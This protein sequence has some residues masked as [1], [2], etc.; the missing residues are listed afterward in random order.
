[1]ITRTTGKIEVRT[2][3][4]SWKLSIYAFIALVSG[5]IALAFTSTA[6]RI[7][8]APGLSAEG[9]VQSIEVAAPEPL[10]AAP[11]ETATN[12]QGQL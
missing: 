6:S 10:A 7:D 12:E 9:S 8:S 11:C 4:T 1:M 5:S 2:M 3:L